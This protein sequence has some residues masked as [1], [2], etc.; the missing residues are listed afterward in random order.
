MAVML[1][2]LPLKRFACSKEYIDKMSCELDEGQR[3]LKFSLQAFNDFIS[4]EFEEKEFVCV[5]EFQDQRQPFLCPKVGRA[6]LQLRAGLD[7]GIA[8]P[9]KAR[10]TEAKIC[11]AANSE[12]VDIP[13]EHMRHTLRVFLLVSLPAELRC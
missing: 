1:K 5:I 7:R 11:T 4:H 9:I 12:P 13:R 2:E 6:D 10:M 8:S 3:L